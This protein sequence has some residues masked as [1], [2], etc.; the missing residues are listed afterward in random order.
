LKAARGGQEVNYANGMNNAIACTVDGV[1]AV[2][3]GG[4]VWVFALE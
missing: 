1:P 4:S 3:E 2:P